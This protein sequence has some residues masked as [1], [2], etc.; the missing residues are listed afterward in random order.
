[1]AV[2]ELDKL[3]GMASHGGILANIVIAA[4]WEFLVMTGMH[5]VI[6]IPGIMNLLAGNPDSC[7]M[8]DGGTANLVN[9]IIATLIAMFSSAAL[10]YLF[11]FD[12]DEPATK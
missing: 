7:V 2:P 5:Q 1:M 3:K 8:V 6:L 4:L 9:Y 10:T 12:K 11:G